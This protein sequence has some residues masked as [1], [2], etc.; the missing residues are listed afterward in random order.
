MVLKYFDE[1]G[2]IIPILHYLHNFV[3][4]LTLCTDIAIINYI[5]HTHYINTQLKQNKESLL[6]LGY[7]FLFLTIIFS[8]IA[9]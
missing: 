1:Y 8:A 2:K 4:S 3:S 6:F 9:H 7:F 5:T